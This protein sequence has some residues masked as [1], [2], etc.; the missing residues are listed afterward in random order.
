MGA[1]GIRWIIAASACGWLVAGPAIAPTQAQETGRRAV[2]RA[3]AQLA[4]AYEEGFL[5]GARQGEFDAR[6]GRDERYDRDAVYRAADR[7]YTSGWG[8]RDAYR[9]EFRR[10]FAAGYRQAYGRARSDSRLDR[11]DDRRDR[12][13]D[14]RQDRRW[15]RGYQE[16]ATA[17]GYADGYAKGVDDVRDR[18]RYDP[19]RH[20]D[21]KD[22]DEGYYREYGSKDAYK[23]NY[24]LGFRQGYEDGYRDGNNNRR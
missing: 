20:G 17:R 9:N 1:R 21:Y 8:S 14:R 4:N 18:D 7:G 23:N 24:R 10:G 6:N 12:R 3:I 22:G 5:D 19:T 13:D 15:G 2:P 11:R 16:P